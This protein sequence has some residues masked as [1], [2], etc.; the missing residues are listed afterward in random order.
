MIKG[1]LI[2]KGIV[3]G[4][5]AMKSRHDAGL[6]CKTTESLCSTESIDEPRE[7]A[8][9][10][11]PPAPVHYRGGFE[12]DKPYLKSATDFNPKKQASEP[13]KK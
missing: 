12:M 11:P 4:L 6:Y 10:A 3:K 5:M 9:K 1:S 8:I 7:S 13:K 2:G